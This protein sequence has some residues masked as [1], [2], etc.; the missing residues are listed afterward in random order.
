MYFRKKKYNDSDFNQA[1]SALTNS[2]SCQMCPSSLFF[3][4]EFSR[5]YWRKGF[6]SGFQLKKVLVMLH[7]APLAP[8]SGC[9]FLWDYNG[10]CVVEINYWS[11]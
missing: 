7:G 3:V 10:S 11:C 9:A 1:I 8:I 4:S 2:G 5:F 6:E